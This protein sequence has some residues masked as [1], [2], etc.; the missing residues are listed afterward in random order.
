MRKYRAKDEYARDARPGPGR[1]AG[2][3]GGHEL[4]GADDGENSTQSVTNSHGNVQTSH[5]DKLTDT[6]IQGVMESCPGKTAMSGVMGFVL[7]GAFGLFM[8]SV[9]LP[10]LFSF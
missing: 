8:S 5:T 2:R 1:H 4:A 10:F 6:Q 7:G 3:H 9:R